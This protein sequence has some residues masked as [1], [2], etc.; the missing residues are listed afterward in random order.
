[1]SRSREHVV[2]H[3]PSTIDFVTYMLDNHA[4]PSIIVICAT[5]EQFMIDILE[6]LDQDLAAS[7]RPSSMIDPGYCLITPTLQLLS[8]SRTIHLAYAPT[9]QHLRAYLG[10]YTPKEATLG[11]D[12]G[13]DR[14]GNS[15]PI[16]ALLN[17]LALH[18]STREFSA[19][20]LSRTFAIAVEAAAR[21]KMQLLVTECKSVLENDPM[22]MNE[23][24]ASQ[25]ERNPW[26]EQIQLLSSG[27]R[28]AGDERIWAGK[29]V[30]VSKS[31][32]RWCRFVD[33]SSTGHEE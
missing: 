24:E 15:Q 7:S 6:L 1:M 26:A 14:Y 13:C 23:D 17:P 29:T 5:Q 21:A 32:S 8:K 19:Q 27:I 25:T 28:S 31:I 11:K 10:T 12:I 30:E 20:G 3:F 2:I 9:L 4:S 33:V 18:R 16:L 22:K